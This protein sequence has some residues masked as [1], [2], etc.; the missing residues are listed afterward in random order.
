MSKFRMLF[1]TLV[2]LSFGTVALAQVCGTSY[3]IATDGTCY[4]TAVLVGWVGPVQTRLDVTNT[5]S[6]DLWYRFDYN[7]QDSWP[8]VLTTQAFRCYS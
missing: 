4:F 7:R 5:T 1:V 6:Q 3:K 2:L 8:E